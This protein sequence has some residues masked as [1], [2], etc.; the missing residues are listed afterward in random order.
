MSKAINSLDVVIA[1]MSAVQ[2]QARLE[3]AARRAAGETIAGSD[4]DEDSEACRRSLNQL[5]TLLA[6]DQKAKMARTAPIAQ[7]SSAA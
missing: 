6:A 1:A 5:R 2:E 4:Q 3:I 7:Q